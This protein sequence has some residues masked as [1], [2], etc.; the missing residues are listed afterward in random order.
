MM[1]ASSR[2]SLRSLVSLPFPKWRDQ[3]AVRLPKATNLGCLPDG[4]MFLSQMKESK[5]PRKLGD[6]LRFMDLNLMLYIRAGSLVHCK[7]HST[8]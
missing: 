7:L 2:T 6:S 5:R 8:Y 4:K 3:K 1:K